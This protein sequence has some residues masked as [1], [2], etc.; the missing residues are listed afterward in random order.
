MRTLIKSIPLLALIALSGCAATPPHNYLAP[1][2][3]PDGL[4]TIAED[5]TP[6][7]AGGNPAKSNS[8]VLP[9]DDF[10]RALADNLGKS[11]YEVSVNQAG[12][13]PDHVEI[14]RYTI[15]WV[16]TDSLYVALTVNNSQRY[17]RSYTV[18]HDTLTP[19]KITIKGYND[20]R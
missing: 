6:I 20:E 17:V 1:D 15:D 2:L 16:S 14:I 8:F 4:T 7:I 3:P 10:G 12:Q 11:G 18:D 9:G 13:L 19:G 5:I